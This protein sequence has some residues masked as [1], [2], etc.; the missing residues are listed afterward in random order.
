MKTLVTGANGFIGS[1][2]VRLLLK[3]GQDVRVLVRPGSD[4]RNFN[5]LELDII[6]GD[7]NDINALRLAVDGCNT[8]YHLAADYRLWIP[9]PENMYKTNVDATRNL[10]IAAA[11]ANVEK[12]VYTSSVATLGL[13]D[14]GTPADEMTPVSI[15][16]MTGHYKRSKYFAEEEVNKLIKERSIPITI[17]NPSTP[18]GPR[19]IKP[20]PTG[21]IVLDT[22]RFGNKWWRKL[23]YQQK[24]I[25]KGECEE[26]GRHQHHIYK[27]QVG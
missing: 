8:L 23:W 16:D 24:Y 21:R 14:D 27:A 7:L 11:E 6:E 13:N 12:I 1:A 17:V 9:D 3:K 4:K 25:D 18:V 20:T 2:V 19:D 26:S 15:E 22:K 10:M 5:G